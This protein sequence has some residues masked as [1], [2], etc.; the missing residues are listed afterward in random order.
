MHEDWKFHH[1]SVV[2]KDMNKA[3]EHYKSLDIG[4]F[5]PFIGPDGPVPLA[6]KTVN[7]KPSDYS[8]DIRHAEGGVG[9]L[10][11]ELV[12][13]VAGGT[14]VKEFLTEKGEGIHHI[15]FTVDN[16]DRETAKL[17][18][19]GFRVTQ[20]GSTPDA[21]WAYYDT[22]AIGGVVIELIEMTS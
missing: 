22:D 15:G 9:Q 12:Q 4:P 20:S 17:A 19:K 10:A 1:V 5:P 3:I 11:F 13:P 7:G 18:E 16:L 2:V 8:V 21:K 6:E 14:P